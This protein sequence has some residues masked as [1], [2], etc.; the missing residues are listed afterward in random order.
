[1]TEAKAEAGRKHSGNGAE[2]TEVEA[3]ASRKPSGRQP[4][5][6]RKPS[7]SIFYHF[8]S[9]IHE[10][11]ISHSP[12]GSGGVLFEPYCAGADHVQR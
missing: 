2:A 1:V 12:V 3:E 5:A 8:Q 7:A 6:K 9:V 10:I 11:Q 4:E